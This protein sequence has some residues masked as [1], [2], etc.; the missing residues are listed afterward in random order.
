M[1]DGLWC[2]FE[3]L[4]QSETER[5]TVIRGPNKTGERQKFRSILVLCAPKITK[6]VHLKLSQLNPLFQSPAGF[7]S[8]LPASYAP[9]GSPVSVVRRPR[10][11]SGTRLPRTDGIQ[12]GPRVPFD[13]GVRTPHDT[14]GS[15]PGGSKVCTGTTDLG[16]GVPTVY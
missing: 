16:F 9:T 5:V 1:K 2:F 3:K 6:F 12:S 13:S 15:H 8:H 7:L 4:L 14:R 10:S 11:R